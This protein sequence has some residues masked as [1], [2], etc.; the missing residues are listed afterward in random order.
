MKKFLIVF[1]VL[2]VVVGP[3]VGYWIKTSNTEKTLRNKIPAQID[4]VDMFYTKLVEILV[5]KAGVTKAYAEAATDFQVAVMEGRYSTGEKMMMWIQEANPT[6]DQSLYKDLM[7]SIEGL[8]EGFFIEQVKLRDL[9]LTHDN[10]I[11][12]F[13]SSLFVGKRGKIDVQILVNVE[14][15]EARETGIDKTPEL[16]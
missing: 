9:K 7:N 13:P 2:L 6:F 16:F 8:R 3:I 10:L 15:K 4:K 5:T 12:I 1:A 14:T 11:D